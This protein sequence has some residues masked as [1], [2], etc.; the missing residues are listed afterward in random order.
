MQHPQREE[1]SADVLSILDDYSNL[2]YTSIVCAQELIHLF[3]IGKIGMGRK[4]DFRDAARTLDWIRS[5]GVTISPVN[6]RHL[7]TMA[8][9]PLFD[10]HRDPFDRL[11]IAQ[12]ITD[13]ITLIS[14]DHKFKHYEPSGL[15]FLFNKR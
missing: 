3:Q 9:L 4:Y 1:L 2:L 7:Q 13:H 10:D 5:I 15:Q 12:A 14:S 11:I 8:E 6:E